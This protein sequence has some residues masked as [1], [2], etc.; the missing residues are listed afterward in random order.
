MTLFRQKG[1]ETDV[2]RMSPSDCGPDPV[3]EVKNRRREV[4]SRSLAEWKPVKHIQKRK[5]VFMF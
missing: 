2:S 5:N 1:F 3:T 4:S